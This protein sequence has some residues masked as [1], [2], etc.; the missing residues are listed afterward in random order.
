LNSIND[1]SH[2]GPGTY[3]YVKNGQ[4]DHSKVAKTAIFKS[5]ERDGHHI[6]LLAK[7]AD[8]GGEHT[9]PAKY[10]GKGPFLKKSFNVS[11]PPS[12]FK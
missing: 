6:N 3:D 2:L 9:G 12:K 8:P 1:T 11:L 5:V 4:Q 7:K 10:I